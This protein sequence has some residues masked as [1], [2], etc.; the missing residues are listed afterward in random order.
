MTNN[1]KAVRAAK[2]G[3]AFVP[4]ITRSLSWWRTMRAKSHN[5][6]TS[7]LMRKA[8]STIAIVGEPRWRPAM[9]GDAAIGMMMSMTPRHY[10][11]L[12]FHLKATV[13][14]ICVVNGSAAACLVMED[15]CGGYPT[16]NPRKRGSRLHGCPWLSVRSS[17]AGSALC[18]SE[19]VKVQ[20]ISDIHLGYPGS[21]G[22]PPLA[23][24]V[25]LVIIGGDTRERLVRAPHEARC[26]HPKPV[27]VAAIAG[28]HDFSGKCYP[29][30]LAAGHAT[31][32]SLGIHFLEND[33]AYFR[34]LRV[35]GCTLWTG[36]KLLAPAS[37]HA[38]ACQVRMVP[39]CSLFDGPYPRPVQLTLRA[40]APDRQLSNYA[41]EKW[42]F[43]DVLMTKHA[44][45]LA[46]LPVPQVHPP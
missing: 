17:T 4:P 3:C 43:D 6:S 35:L 29:D 1:S 36:Y 8:L 38:N 23:H 21:V 30:E 46:I 39:A 26:A 24:G 41:G 7:A 16:R 25:D 37:R 18:A 9:S 11:S 28:R 14:A 44:N 2:R 32:A 20:I 10:G 42:L 15:V 5:D 40:H 27:K 12:K 22:F 31:A 45:G 33:V 19:V 34:S 13:L